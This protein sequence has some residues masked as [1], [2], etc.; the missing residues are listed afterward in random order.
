MAVTS[1]MTMGRYEIQSPGVMAQITKIAH[2]VVT[3]LLWGT[4]LA[5]QQQKPF[6]V[7]SVVDEP[8]KIGRAH[9]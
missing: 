7:T 5:G 2:V 4:I 1:G 9:V 6:P 3:V 8:T